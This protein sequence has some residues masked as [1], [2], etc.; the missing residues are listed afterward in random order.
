MLKR[1]VKNEK[2]GKSFVEYFDDGSYFFDNVFNQEHKGV[3]FFGGQFC[4]W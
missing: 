4:C 1:R 2:K 3:C